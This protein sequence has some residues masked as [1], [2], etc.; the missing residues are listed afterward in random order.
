MFTVCCAGLGLLVPALAIAATGESPLSDMHA[1][2]AAHRKT[3][4][5]LETE[6]SADHGLRARSRVV[7]LILFQE[8]HQRAT[9][10]AERLA[11]DVRA[12]ARVGWTTTPAF[13]S[14]FL[15]ALD[16]A[17]DWRDA[18]RLA[19]RDA[20]ASLRAAAG[21]G[22]SDYPAARAFRGRLDAAARSLAATEALYGE[23]LAGLPARAPR[24]PP[25]SLRSA[26]DRYV[27]FVCSLYDRDAILREN[28]PALEAIERTRVARGLPE[29]PLEISGSDLPLGTVLLTFD[30]GPHARFTDRILETLVEHRVKAV[31]FE[32]GERVGRVEQDEA[33]RESSGAA[34]AQRVHA[35]G[36][37]IGNH[38]FT[39]PLMPRLSDETIADEIEKT[40]RLLAEITGQ[41]PVLFRPPYGAADERVLA[42]VEARGMRSVLWTVDS[43]DWAD[44]IAASI[45]ERVI[46]E[47]R[48]QGCGIVLFHDIH[49]QTA[50]ALP[51]VLDVLQASG[52]RFLAGNGNQFVG[53]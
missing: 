40:N 5:L 27:A 12:A 35:A 18:D 25:A 43:K 47:I 14:A 32:V 38:S 28:A 52:W 46:R 10:L 13:A 11:A 19:F 41:Q 34:V 3:I 51:V 39:H 33:L 24:P 23:E 6:P 53:K 26:W 50:D 42:A 45:A 30:D 31:F 2:V 22:R 9:R 44:P 37:A 15:D 8:N 4:V 20:L 17:S 36:M 29:S 16:R 21:R 48:S 1:I 49:G 7:G